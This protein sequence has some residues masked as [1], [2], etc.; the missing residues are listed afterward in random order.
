MVAGKLLN[1]DKELIYFELVHTDPGKPIGLEIWFDQQCL[2]GHNRLRENLTFRHE[3]PN[4]LDQHQL[5]IVI[6]NKTPAHTVLD[7]H[8]NTV[9]DTALKIENFRLNDILIIDSFFNLGKYHV[10][11][12][13]TPL[14]D[15][16]GY[17]GFNGT[18]IFDFESPA[19]HWAVKNYI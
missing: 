15:C 4:K 1:S 13:V 10:N 6:K 19:D 16:Y 18:V 3:F 9:S 17:L 12:R 2:L 14:I 5:K 11:D 8:G 7:S